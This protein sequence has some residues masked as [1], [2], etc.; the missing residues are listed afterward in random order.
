V[1]IY[2]YLYFPFYYNTN[3]F[4]NQVFSAIPTDART[5]VV[6]GRSYMFGIW[7]TPPT[8]NSELAQINYYIGITK[9]PTK[10]VEPFVLFV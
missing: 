3:L 5:Y 4:T 9:G 7:L 2:L 1:L 8:G 6:C 10:S